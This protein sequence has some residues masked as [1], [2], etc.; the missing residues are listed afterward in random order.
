MDREGVPTRQLMTPDIITVT[1]ATPIDEAVNTLIENDI[2]SL[3]VVDDHNKLAGVI[4]SNDI[5]SVVADDDHGTDGTVEEYMTDEV[6]TIDPDDDIQTAAARMITNG[7]S[8]LP[9]EDDDGIIGM[10]STTDI[11]AYSVSRA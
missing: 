7:I 8:H 4:T 2:S 1:P 3:I 5:L 11:T 10:L 6:V 9:V